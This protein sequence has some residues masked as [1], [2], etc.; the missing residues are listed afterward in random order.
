[1]VID[2][3]SMTSGASVATGIGALTPGGASNAQKPGEAKKPGGFG[4]ILNTEIGKTNAPKVGV[5]GTK[6]DGVKF[7]QHA[8]ERMA[9]RGISFK[10]EEMMRLNEAIGKAEQKG[11]RETLVLMGDSALIVSV[12]NKTVV[13][14]M[15]REAMKE[16]IFT[17][18][19]STVIL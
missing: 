17:N 13:T 11:S 15:D 3:P 14:A 2:K 9:N 16:N 12:K 8:L 6:F 10:P 18:I 7:S 1:M 4:D 5:P 19:D